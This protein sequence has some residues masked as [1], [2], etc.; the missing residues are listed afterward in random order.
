[1]RS[2]PPLTPLPVAYATASAAALGE[3]IAAHYALDG[4]VSCSFVNRG[5]NDTYAVHAAG[6]AQF[7]LRLSSPRARGP[8]DVAAETAFIAHLD[9]AGMP[10]AAPVPARCSPRPRCRCSLRSGTSG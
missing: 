1:M 4:P 8:A 10:V 3:F 7:I 2:P 9:G 5:F 6:G